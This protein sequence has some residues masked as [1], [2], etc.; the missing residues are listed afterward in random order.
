MNEAMNKMIGQPGGPGNG[1][2]ARMGYDV[3]VATGLRDELP[4]IPG[5]RERWARDVLHC[6]YCH[7]YEVKDE[8]LGVLGTHPAA[9]HHALL[10]RQW[11]EN[12]VF[13]PHTLDLS[14]DDRERITAR[15]VQIVDGEISRLVTEDD[16]L[17]GVELA[18]GQVV[19]RSAVFVFPRMVPNDG[20]LTGVG[21]DRDD[22]GWVTIDATGRT[23]VPGVWAVGNVVDPRAQVITAAGNGSAAAIALNHDLLEEEVRQAVEQYRSADPLADAPAYR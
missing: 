3:V 14:D 13:M 19:P 12:V 1:E 17:C 11:S 23:S 20:L 8:P 10:L 15:G 9:V 5:L 6:P 7:G 16:Q 22:R 2:A 21:C 4:D 18:G